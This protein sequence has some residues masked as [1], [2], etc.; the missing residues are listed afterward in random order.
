[1]SLH[2]DHIQL[3]P[4]ILPERL[5]EPDAAAF[6]NFRISVFFPDWPARF[7]SRDFRLFA[8]NVIREN[9]PAHVAVQTFWL[10]V[11]KMQT[12][13]DLYERWVKARTWRMTDLFGQQSSA[14]PI[15]MEEEMQDLQQWSNYL[16]RLTQQKAAQK[17]YDEARVLAAKALDAAQKVR[18]QLAADPK[19][20]QTQLVEW[21]ARI[22]Q[23]EHVMQ[24]IDF[25]IAELGYPTADEQIESVNDLADQLRQF[26]LGLPSLKRSRA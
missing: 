9:A 6:Y 21:E 25:I 17:L 18:K 22:K 10:D 24:L 20:T 16:L 8:E 1:M 11:E 15:V 13:E 2:D 3:I 7:Q 23:I 19:T 12:F 26:I 5:F 14:V 4:E